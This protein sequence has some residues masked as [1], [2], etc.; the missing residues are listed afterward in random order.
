MTFPAGAPSPALSGKVRTFVF[1]DLHFLAYDGYNHDPDLP[2]G[3]PSWQR[4]DW[5]K[6]IR[7]SDPPKDELSAI[8]A[9]DG[10]SPVAAMS[11]CQG[12]QLWRLDPIRFDPDNPDA[13]VR[14]RIPFAADIDTRLRFVEHTFPVRI[15]TMDAVVWM[16]GL[17]RGYAGVVVP[18]DPDDEVVQPSAAAKAAKMFAELVPA[19]VEMFVRDRFRYTMTTQ[20][21]PP[22]PATLQSE[23]LQSVH[24]ALTVA[25]NIWTLVNI[26]LVAKDG[27]SLTEEAFAQTLGACTCS[28]V[29]LCHDV[30]TNQ[31]LGRVCVNA[32][33]G[34]AVVRPDAP[35]ARGSNL[36]GSSIASRNCWLRYTRPQSTEEGA[37]FHIPAYGALGFWPRDI[38]MFSIGTKDV[39]EETFADLEYSDWNDTILQSLARLPDIDRAILLVNQTHCGKFAFNPVDISAADATAVVLHTGTIDPGGQTYG[40]LSKASAISSGEGISAWDLATETVNAIM[41][42]E[43]GNQHTHQPN[44][45]IADGIGWDLAAA[46][47][48]IRLRPTSRALTFSLDA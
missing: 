9:E 16:G 5:S 15:G 26:S 7:V 43:W 21:E 18:F 40:L 25:S 44:D 34:V 28:L 20:R 27:E 48:V 19:F 10:D 17:F 12:I 30:S 24:D 3:Q 35:V 2:S 46:C 29:L 31:E 38:L 33:G 22:D 32:G 11:A 45:L 47:V 36:D 1:E 41:A 6:P 42:D 23:L 37:A 14:E 4:V 8:I 13:A 39:N